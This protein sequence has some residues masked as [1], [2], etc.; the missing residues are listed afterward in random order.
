MKKYFANPVPLSYKYQFIEKF[1]PVLKDKKPVGMEH[2]KTSVSR[3]AADPSCVLFRGKYWLFPSMSKGFWVSDDLIDWQFVS[4]KN[5]PHYDYAPDVQVRGEYLYFCASDNVGPCAFYR[6]KDPMSGV[7]EKLSATMT[8]WDPNLF[9]DDDGRVYFYWGC[10]NSEPVCG[11]ELDPETLL[12]QGEKVGLIAGKEKEHGFERQGND[13]LEPQLPPDASDFDKMLRKFFGTS[14][15]IEGAWMT[16]YRGKYYLQY[17]ALGTEFN[18]YGDGVY[19]SDS[20]LKGFVY[21]KNNPYSYKPGGFMTG[22]GHG[23]TLQ[24]KEGAW[25]HF[26]TMQISVNHAYE[27]R[28]GLFPAG[29]DED[30][31]LFSNQRYGDWVLDMDALRRDV[32]AEPEFMLLSYGK[33]VRASSEEAGRPAS[34]AVNECAKNWWRAKDGGEAWVEVDLGKPMRVRAVQLNFADELPELPF[35]AGAESVHKNYE[36]RYIDDTPHFTRWLLEGSSDGENYETI[37]DKRQAET[38]LPHELVLCDKAFRYV[39]CTVTELPFGQNA[40][41]SGLRVFGLDDGKKPAAPK[42]KEALRKSALDA[43]IAWEGEGC[44]YTVLWGHAPDKLYHSSTVFGAKEYRIGALNA[45]QRTWV[46]VDAFNESGITH[47]ETV[48]II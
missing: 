35:P 14:P 48:E 19:V 17:A 29:F 31:E 47:G 5:T 43:D 42:I 22:A 20:P 45:E 32:W 46:R 11:V 4:L 41:L 3:E 6:T 34:N 8:F 12:A 38:D 25:W 21:Q 1:R 39:R 28:V 27:R 13:H 18:V 24:D 36:T 16:K 30:G 23:S 44:G 15:F 26:S 40:A 7:F 2:V 37:L 10:S 33:Q 9:F